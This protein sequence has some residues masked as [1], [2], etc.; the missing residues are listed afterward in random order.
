[1]YRSAV[2]LLCLSFTSS[3][4]IFLIGQLISLFSYSLLWQFIFVD[5]QNLGR[6]VVCMVHVH[7][8]S[9]GAPFASLVF[10]W[11]YGQLLI[12]YCP[13]C[14][15][16]GLSTTV[17]FMLL[18][19]Q[20]ASSLLPRCAGVVVRIHEFCF[21]ACLNLDRMVLHASCILV[22]VLLMSTVLVARAGFKSNQIK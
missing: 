18:C 2:F 12:V 1:M 4:S 10:C 8:V 9:C 15:T 5:C 19:G 3:C 16:I 7:H 6:A 14:F 11:Y 13:I 22:D 17:Y 20:Q 21:P